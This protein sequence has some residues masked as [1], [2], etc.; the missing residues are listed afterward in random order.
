MDHD[1][2]T[3]DQPWDKPPGGD[4]ASRV[5]SHTCASPAPMSRPR[6]R[7]STIRPVLGLGHSLGGNGRGAGG[8]SRATAMLWSRAKRS[9]MSSARGLPEPEGGA[10]PRRRPSAPGD[11]GSSC[12]DRRRIRPP[13][14]H[15][16]GT[17]GRCPPSGASLVSQVRVPGDLELPAPGKR[18]QVRASAARERLARTIHSGAGHAAG[19]IRRHR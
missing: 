10:G 19:A 16:C 5:T 8:S 13:P 4:S 3:R 2:A 12:R 14:P 11:H 1:R 15:A 9:S 6:S 7:A 18:Q 17:G